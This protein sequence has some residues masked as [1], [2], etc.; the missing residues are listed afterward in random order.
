[1]ALLS[2][3]YERPVEDFV[4]TKMRRAAKLWNEGEKALAHIHQSY[5][6]L[7]PCD[8]DLALRLFFA[9]EL[10]EAGVT[11]ASLMQA[12]GFDPAPLDL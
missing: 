3:A 7:A 9:E 1:M 6:S 5:V 8:T 4:L 12:Q 11:P 10:I 2:M